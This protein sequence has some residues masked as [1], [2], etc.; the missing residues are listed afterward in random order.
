LGFIIGIEEDPKLLG[1]PPP[2]PPPPPTEGKLFIYD[3]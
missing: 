1:L 2:P 3:N